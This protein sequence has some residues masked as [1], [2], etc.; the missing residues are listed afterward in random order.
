M[1][2]Q[3]RDQFERVR[4]V[5]MA[6]KEIAIDTET[7]GLLPYEGDQVAG[8]STYC[9]ITGSEYFLAAYF[10]F[11]HKP[12]ETLLD[13]SENLPL[14]WMREIATV[15]RRT[16]I[17]RLWCYN[18]KFDT[19]FLL[20][21]GIDLRPHP[22]HEGAIMAH[23]RRNH[24]SHEL[25]DV[26]DEFWPGS[27]DLE[28]EMK[29]LVA[30]YGG[31][32]AV[33][34]KLM[35][36]Y[37]CKDAELHWNVDHYLLDL[38]EEEYGTELLTQLLDRKYRFLRLVQQIEEAGVGVD[39][40]RCEELSA[41]AA[42]QMRR[43][44]D[45]MGFD[46]G[47]KAELA[48]RLFGNAPTGLGLLPGPLTKTPSPDFPKGMP[49]TAQEVLSPH[50]TIP[51]VASVLEYRGLVKAKSTW[52]DGFS[53]RLER[54]DGHRLHPSI[55][56]T[57]TLSGRISESEPNLNQIP[58]DDEAV[59]TQLKRQVKKV[60][61]AGRPGWRLYEFDYSQI[62]LRIAAKYGNATPLLDA[63][64]AGEDPHKVTASLIG[65]TRQTAKHATYTVLYGGQA[66]TLARTV[67]RLEFQTTGKAVSYPVSEAEDILNRFFELYPGMR[68]VA[69]NSSAL[70]K[71]RGY[72][73][74]WDG[75]RR[76]FWRGYS[77]KYKRMMDNSHAAFNIICQGGASVIMEK[78]MLLLDEWNINKS[79]RMVNQVHDSIW[80]EVQEDFLDGDIEEIK[81]IMEWPSRDPQWD[82]P[83]G[84]DVKL[85]SAA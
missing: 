44:E 39:R 76:R 45:E 37:A 24:S 43:L 17:E 60:F 3:T 54:G 85:L 14:D 66:S 46:P 78:S 6:A 68:T 31:Y 29:K 67:E 82:I 56:V 59:E 35:E 58:R 62:E 49:S 4:T 21:D 41:E 22:F 9:Q 1:L 53:G 32:S 33:P 25:K 71:Q 63:L 79:W 61:R 34:P 26:A 57:G 47:K 75:Q 19:T 23:L 8:I 7:T 15:F 5:L 84:V 73:Q 40:Q 36:P 72:I 16:D 83:F 51:L 20:K 52:F 55:N 42:R 81:N 28:Q 13:S 11:R 18:W 69:A 27:S 65:C 80:M 12:G 74:L 70:I 64:R 50:S 2:V 10:P 38:L 77:P 30:K 48:R